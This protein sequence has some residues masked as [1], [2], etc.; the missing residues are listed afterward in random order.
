MLSFAYISNVTCGGQLL[1]RLLLLLLLMMY[2]GQSCLLSSSSSSSLPK[3]Y[4]SFVD[5]MM[6]F[7]WSYFTTHA[8]T[9]PRRDGSHSTGSTPY[10]SHSRNDGSS[11]RSSTDSG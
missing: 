11:V 2:I 10:A 9:L 6:S 1:L 8:S 4:L 5:R 3:P 7:T